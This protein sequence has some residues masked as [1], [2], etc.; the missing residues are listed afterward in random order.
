MYIDT[1]AYEG[2]DENDDYGEETNDGDDDN[3]SED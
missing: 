1:Y 3:P 2:D